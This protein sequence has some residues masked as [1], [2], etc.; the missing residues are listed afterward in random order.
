MLAGAVLRRRFLDGSA[1][2]A[3]VGARPLWAASAHQRTIA[4]LTPPRGRLLHGTFPGGFT[5]EEDDITLAQVKTY[6]RAVGKHVAWVMFSHNWFQGRRFPAATARWIIAHGS[7]PYIRLMLR[8]DSREMAREPHYT[9]E[10]IAAGE[11]DADL[12]RWG[13]DVAALGVPVIA[14]YGT[15]M[16]GEWFRWNGR[17]NGRAKGGARFRA[18]YRHIIE[19]T[20]AAG[21]DNIVWVFHIN[22]ADWPRARW[23][24]F[25]N[26]YPGDDVIDWL[27]VSLYSMLGPQEDEATGFQE[28]LDQPYARLRRMSPK[29]PIIVSE[30]GTDIH[31][32]REPAAAWADRALKALL[33]GRWPGVIGFSWWNETWPNDDGVAT[34]L[35]VW[36]DADLARVFR[37]RLRNS[38]IITRRQ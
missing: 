9:L 32:P 34:D 4:A 21:G 2:V 12:A 10:K 23:N 22:H 6:E 37:Q 27:G 20:R 16:N 8:S 30:F 28:G 33:G 24:R 38:P 11:F 13:Q 19:V 35:R 36:Q 31:N 1:A 15:E 18:A 14:E 29:K 5:G 7:T 17:W 26:Y 3:A 25:E